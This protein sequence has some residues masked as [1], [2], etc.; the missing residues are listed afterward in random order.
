MAAVPLQTIM[1]RKIQRLLTNLYTRIKRE[2]MTSDE[3]KSIT[4]ELPQELL[5]KIDEEIAK[6]KV[7]NREQYI[8]EALKFC[9]DAE[10]E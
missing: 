1:C 3:D 4:V 6:G 5:D 7:I 10:D 9:I 2:T 8:L